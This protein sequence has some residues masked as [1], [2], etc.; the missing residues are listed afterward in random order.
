MA[1]RGGKPSQRPTSGNTAKAVVQAAARDT[2][3][4]FHILWGVFGTESN[5]GANPS[6]SSAGA[7][8]PFQ[9]LPSTWQQW[10]NGGNIM[11]VSDS[12]Y[13]AGR[14]LNYLFN[15]NG[16]NWNAALNAY[17]G[18]SGGTSDT[19]Y[20]ASV[21]KLGGNK[22][23]GGF[24]SGIEHFGEDIIG[25]AFPGLGIAQGWS[26]GGKHK[27]PVSAFIDP[28]KAIGAIA[29]TILNPAKWGELLANTIAVVLRKVFVAVYKYAVLPPWHWTQRAAD[30][31]AINEL[32]ITGKPDS[33]PVLDNKALMTIGFWSFGFVLLWG[34]VEEQA[35]RDEQGRFVKSTKFGIGAKPNQSALGKTISGTIMAAK[36]TRLKKDP[37][38]E[39]KVKPRPQVSEVELKINRYMS[40]TRRRAVTVTET[41][42]YGTRRSY[43][44]SQSSQ[45]RIQQA[46]DEN[47]NV[48]DARER[49]EAHRRKQNL[50][51]NYGSQSAPKND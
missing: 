43:R 24:L 29:E 26:P 8:G 25:G 16:R 49:I 2:G 7:E 30:Y 20:T 1:L 45:G 28:I 9:F 35:M 31:Y 44:T 14:Y 19:S 34:Q 4:P 18:N 15:Q 33:N 48:I 12:A 3:T 13:A 6:T 50:R 37:E 32:T 11:S 47:A 10:G 5:F 42:P 21:Y 27:N 23:S 51:K 17:N 38:K 41:S 39:T 36:K 22:S 40:A 46:S